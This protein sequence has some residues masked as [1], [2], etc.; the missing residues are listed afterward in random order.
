[1]TLAKYLQAS[2]QFLGLS[3]AEALMLPPGVV[4][5]LIDL[6]RGRR[7]LNRHEEDE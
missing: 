5:D 4:M 3:V 2:T 1:M 6:E 7:G